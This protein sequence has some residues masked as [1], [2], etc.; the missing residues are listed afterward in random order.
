MA[1]L[2]RKVMRKSPTKKQAAKKPQAKAK[3]PAA[4]KPEVKAKK[5]AVK[6]PQAETKKPAAKKPEAKKTVK[7]AKTKDQTKTLADKRKKASKIP[8][9]RETKGGSTQSRGAKAPERKSAGDANAPVTESACL[10]DGKIAFN[11]EQEECLANVSTNKSL[12]RD[13]HCVVSNVFENMPKELVTE[14]LCLAVVK[15]NG[16]TLLY[17]PNEMKTDAVCRAA[18]EDTGFLGD[19]PQ[20]RKTEELCLIAAQIDGDALRYVPKRLM[21]EAIC[22]AA[23]KQDADALELVPKDLR[24]KVKAVIDDQN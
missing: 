2:K 9:A 17:V 21:T 22:I 15:K 12:W 11:K 14:E 7:T 18:V 19:V 4:K 5:Q 13:G 16:H 6:K 20:A 23:V 1:K 10:K 24:A 3:K 8:G